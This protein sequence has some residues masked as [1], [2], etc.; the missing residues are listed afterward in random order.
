MPGPGRHHG[1]GRV[2]LRGINNGSAS[3]YIVI[4]RAKI[5]PVGNSLGIRLPK[6]ILAQSEISGEVEL[7]ASRHEIVI[8]AAR[9]PRDG[10]EEAFAAKAGGEQGLLVPS[11]LQNE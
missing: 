3:N 5:V 1:A 11:K 9:R 2:G 7:S 10:W 4:M 6:A 8:R